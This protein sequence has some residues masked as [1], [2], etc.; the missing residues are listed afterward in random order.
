MPSCEALDPKLLEASVVDLQGKFLRF[1]VQTEFVFFALDV[2]MY[3]IGHN[4]VKKDLHSL[5]GVGLFNVK[6][7]FMLA[8]C[9]NT[10]ESSKD[11]VFTACVLLVHLFYVFEFL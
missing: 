6:A 10:S 9:Q 7:S 8:Q 3:L 5:F 4:L 1:S 2:K 11:Q